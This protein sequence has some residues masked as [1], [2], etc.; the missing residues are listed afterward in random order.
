MAFAYARKFTYGDFWRASQKVDIERD[1]GGIYF[2]FF[3]MLTVFSAAAVSS[4]PCL[5]GPK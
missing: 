4:L 3:V 5:Y 2:F 1:Y